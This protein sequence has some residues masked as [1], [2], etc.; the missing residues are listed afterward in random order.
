MTVAD[1]VSTATDFLEHSEQQFVSG[2]NLQGSDKL[3]GAV[4]HSV[5]AVAMQRGWNFSEH[6]ARVAAVNRLAQEY[7]QPLLQ[8]DFSVG[9]KFHANF[10]HD[11]MENDEIA[12]DRPIVAR[13][14]RRIL[15]IV[16]AEASDD[17]DQ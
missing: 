1:H 2:D 8:S 14:V 4:S 17:P 7:E 3:W 6:N 12:R 16:A 5:M 10:Y 9:E 11:F 15:E 13:F